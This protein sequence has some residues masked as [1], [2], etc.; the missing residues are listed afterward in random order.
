MEDELALVEIQLQDL[1][2]QQTALLEKRARLNAVISQQEA[3][4]KQEDDKTWEGTGLV[5][6]TV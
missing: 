2:E 6:L 3:C 4:R 1:L 5:S